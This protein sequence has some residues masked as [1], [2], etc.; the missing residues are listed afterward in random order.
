MNEKGKLYLIPTRLGDNPP[1]EVLPLSIK[2]IIEQLDDY[3]VEN[4][5]TA[6]RFIKRVVPNKPQPSLRLKVLNKYTQQSELNSFLDPCENGLS[7]GIISEAGCP[8]I[9]DPGSDIVSIAHDKNITVVPLVGPSSILLALMSSGM[10]GQSFAFN[11]YLPIDKNERK[12]EIKTLE[13]RSA[14]LNQTQLF[15]ETPYRNNQMLADLVSVLN[16]N[17]RICVACDLTLPTEFIKTKP[18]KDWKNS[19]EDLHKRPTIFVIQKD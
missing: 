1:L 4:E 13:R 6:R 18:A 9:A 17:T 14:E 5:K 19:K 2:K 15:I 8:A 10:N 11:G 16:P 12:K 7:M 3:I